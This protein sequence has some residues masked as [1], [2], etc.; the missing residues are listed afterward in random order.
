MPSSR[1]HCIRRFTTNASIT[2]SQ[3]ALHMQ[4][5]E[6][7]QQPVPPRLPSESRQWVVAGLVGDG[8]LNSSHF[9]QTTFDMPELDDG[10]ALI[11]VKLIN[12]HSATRLRIVRLMIAPGQTDPNNYACGEVIQSRDPAFAVGDIV[13]CQ[14][15]WQEYQII[16]SLNPPVGF[17]EPSEL[18]RA[19]NRTNSAWNYVFRSACGRLRS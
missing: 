6:L 18:V 14:A 3:E 5:V 9:E 11:R 16:S 15:G 13:A 19:L 7:Q 10:Q 1:D 4:S 8:R 2:G 12:I 17:N